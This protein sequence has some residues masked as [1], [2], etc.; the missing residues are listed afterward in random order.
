MQGRSLL[1][2]SDN[3]QNAAYFAP[4]FE[5]TSG[6]IALRTAIYQAIIN[7][8]EPLNFEDTTDLV[9]KYWRRFGNPIVLD[10]NGEIIQNRQRMFDYLIGFV[11]A[12]FCTPGGRRNSLESLGLVRLLMRPQMRN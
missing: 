7:N 3:R 4:Y 10:A 12:E 1:T 5:S 2:F 6:G 9:L 11:I 8:G